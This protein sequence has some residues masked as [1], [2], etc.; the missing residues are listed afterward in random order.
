MRIEKIYNVDTTRQLIDV[1]GDLTN[2]YLKFNLTSTDKKP[3]QMSISDV[4]EE[5]EF[6]D[7]EDGYI[8]GDFTW[9]ENDH[10]DFFIVLKSNEETEINVILDI[11]D[12]KTNE[13]NKMNS[14]IPQQHTNIN[15]IFDEENHPRMQPQVNMPIQQQPIPEDDCES[16]G[17]CGTII[18]YRYYIIAVIV[19]IIAY[20][21]YKNPAIIE[22]IKSKIRV[23]PTTQLKS[24]SANTSKMSTPVDNF[25]SQLENLKI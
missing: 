11:N 18:K 15:D 24:S 9:N 2:F 13:N 5:V 10:K 4:M 1:N 7:V 3:F 25:S 12:L 17:I 20:N 6:K 16:G 21:L 23:A 8:N 22:Q 19:V 14:E